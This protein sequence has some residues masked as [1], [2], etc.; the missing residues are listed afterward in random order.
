M[1]STNST[2]PATGGAALRTPSAPV[3]KGIIDFE[4]IADYAGTG[5]A[6]AGPFLYGPAESFIVPV[7]TP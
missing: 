7:C 6:V 5:M 4:P 3:L 1:K 2:D